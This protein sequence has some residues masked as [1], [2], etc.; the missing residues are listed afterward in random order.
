MPAGPR[1]R[2]LAAG[3]RRGLPPPLLLGTHRCLL[4]VLLC[5]SSSSSV[6]W[7]GSAGA[8]TGST[9]RPRRAPADSPSVVSASHSARSGTAV[10][11]GGANAGE[12][13]VREAAAVRTSVSA[14]ASHSARTSDSGERIR[15]GREPGTP[16]ACAVGGKE[17]AS[18]RSH[19]RSAG[20]S[21]PACQV[22]TPSGPTV[23][24]SRPRATRP[25][26]P[27]SPEREH[28]LARDLVRYEDRFAVQHRTAR[29]RLI[30]FH[31]GGF[32]TIPGAAR[33]VGRAGAA[34]TVVLWLL[35][36]RHRLSG[37]PVPS[38]K[39]RVVAGVPGLAQSWG[40]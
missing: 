33:R 38:V 7:S 20:S 5:V 25:S 22:S 17:S 9:R 2:P 19:A 32:G 29:Y 3:S 27:G 23:G 12:H 14:I 6:H 31:Q 10:G 11:S 28:A 4:C 34:A 39:L 35:R 13:T 16:S 37:A 40:A 24:N 1:H 18:S 36:C 15:I 26:G 8:G 30:G 21:G